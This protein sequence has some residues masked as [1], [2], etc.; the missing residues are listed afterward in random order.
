M[1]NK[2]FTLA[3]VLGV[4]VLLSLLAA[5]SFSGITNRLNNSKQ[6]ISEA[7]ETL[8]LNSAELYVNENRLIYEK[9]AGN[10]YCILVE[11]LIEQEYLSSP[12]LDISGEEIDYKTK[13]KVVYLNDKF[14][15]TY[16][17]DEC[18]EVK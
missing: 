16:N 5:I 4:I 14:Q 10:V 18:T 17:P 12:I 8:I 6:E 2:G 1:Y 9:K 13:V 15:F 11:S 3:E 7:Q